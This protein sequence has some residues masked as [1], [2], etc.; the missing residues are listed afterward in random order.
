MSDQVLRKKLIRLAHAR[1]DLRADI[2]PILKSAVSFTPPREFF[3]PKDNPTLLQVRGT[4]VGLEIWTWD[5]AGKSYGIAFAGKA[6]KPLWYY[7][8]RSDSARQMQIDQT[9]KSYAS[10][11][12]LKKQRSEERKQFRHDLS[13]GDILYSSWGYDQTNINWYEVVQIPS[14]K[15]VVLREVAGKILRSDGMGSDQVVP[16]R[17]SYVGPAMKRIPRG[18]LG[19]VSVKISD[20]QTAY[21]WD[22]KPKRETSSGWGH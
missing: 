2:L 6:N 16:L 19:S 14:E 13:V 4:P 8:F 9:I 18:S 22:G 12:A 20:A 7:A 1:P 11:Q 10:S 3:I 17:G 21:K 15:M 5:L